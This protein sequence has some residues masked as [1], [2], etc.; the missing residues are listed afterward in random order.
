MTIKINAIEDDP[1]HP[2]PSQ[3]ALQK[4][5]DLAFMGLQQ[6]DPIEITICNVPKSQIHELNNQYRGKDKPTNVLSFPFNETLDDALYAGDVI[7]CG[8]VIEQ[9]ANDLNLSVDHHWAH[10]IIHSSLHLQGHTHEHDHDAKIMQSLEIEL[11][12][13]IQIDNP[14]T[15]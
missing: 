7:A 9:E 5:V 8:Q 3:K 13:K 2:L 1:E 12:H 4:Y 6:P 15:G 14:Y 11:L 10:L